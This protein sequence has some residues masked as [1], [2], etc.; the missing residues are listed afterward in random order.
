MKPSIQ[1]IY[2]N[3]QA[4]QDI[5]KQLSLLTSDLYTALTGG[6]S[7]SDGENNL[8]FEIQDVPMT[9]GTSTKLTYKRGTGK[10]VF[11]GIPIAT[12]NGSTINSL[13]MTPKGNNLTVNVTLSSPTDIVRFLLIGS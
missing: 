6:L 4:D 3:K 12:I 7:L 1:S 2:T 9:S 11:G 8:P 5:V 10:N 13:Q